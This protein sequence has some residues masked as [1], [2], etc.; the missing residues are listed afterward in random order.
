MNKRCVAMPV[1]LAFVLHRECSIYSQVMP[2]IIS[3]LILPVISRS[4]QCTQFE[5]SLTLTII[6]DSMILIVSRCQN[7]S[8]FASR[9][10]SI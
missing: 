3:G 7:G 10:E 6:F 2:V 5:R 8:I 9:R 1:G 4:R